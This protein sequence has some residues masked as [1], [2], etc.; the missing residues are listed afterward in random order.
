MSIAYQLVNPQIKGSLETTVKAENSLKAAKKIYQALSEHFNNNVPAFYFT[1]QKG[2]SGKGKYYHFK[3]T[4]EKE[5][6]E[7]SYS[8]ESFRVADEETKMKQFEGHRSQFERKQA[9][10]AKRKVRRSSKSSRAE[11]DEDLF[12]SD[13]DEYYRTAQRSNVTYAPITWWWYDP[14]VYELEYV[15][16]PTFYPY[17]TPFVEYVIIP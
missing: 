5:G 15:Y 7:V 3:V 1:I 8:I 10:G 17:V 6:D 9:G 14:F 4:E 12:Q 11:S 13:D 16:I 2:A